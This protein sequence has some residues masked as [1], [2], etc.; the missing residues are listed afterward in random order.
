MLVRLYIILMLVILDRL[1]LVELQ[2]LGP[3][4]VQMVGIQHY[5]QPTLLPNMNIVMVDL[6]PS[7]EVMSMRIQLQNL[8]ILFLDKVTSL[9][10]YGLR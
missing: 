1:I 3:I 8:V 10:K 4:L 9:L 7:M 5:S 2:L 6:L